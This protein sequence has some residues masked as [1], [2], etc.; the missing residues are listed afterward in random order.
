MELIGWA[1][2]LP[3]ESKNCEM[4]DA[5]LVAELS[6]RWSFLAFSQSFKNVFAEGERIGSWPIR[7]IKLEM[8]RRTWA[9]VKLDGVFASRSYSR[10]ILIAL[11]RSLA[12]VL[13]LIRTPSESRKAA[14]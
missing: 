2:F 1:D 9:S 14:W 5:Y 13:L 7:S 10:A 11:E 12:L 4:V 8:E 3:K 6:E